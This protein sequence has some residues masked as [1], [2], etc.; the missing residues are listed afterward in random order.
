MIDSHCHVGFDELKENIDGYLARAQSQ[1]V[2]LILTVACHEHQ[3]SDLYTI[4]E[5][6]PTIFGAFGVNP[7]ENKQTISIER[8]KE[9]VQ[10]PKIIGIGETGFD[11]FYEP[12]SFDHQKHNF[13]IHAQVAQET[14]LP[15]II[16]SRSADA[17]TIDLLKNFKDITGVIHCFTGS[18]DFAKKALDLGYYISASG[19]ITFK[20][21]QELRDIFKTI[22]LDR[23]LIETDAPYLAPEPYRGQINE[24]VYVSKVL[25]KLA[26]I[27]DISPQELDKITTQNFM[28]LFKKVR[29][30]I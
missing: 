30:K 22:P 9:I 19:I 1:S 2:Q 28:N 24:S 29:E 12:D 6:Y 15:L 18:A 20:K 10:H 4:L 27:K 21:S 26:E 16:H 13:E 14:D 23:L 8:L 5:N 17:Q 25:E 3:L 7:Q 11:L